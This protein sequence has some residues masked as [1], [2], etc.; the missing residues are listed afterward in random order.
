[1]IEAYR[2]VH[3]G[4]SAVLFLSGPTLKQYVEPEPNLIKCGVNTVLFHRSDL[5]YFFIQDIGM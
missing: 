4:R 1:M 5:D 2:N 3:L